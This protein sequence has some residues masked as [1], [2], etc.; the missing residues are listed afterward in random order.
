VPYGSVRHRVHDGRCPAT[1]VNGDNDH[2]G[3]ESMIRS[4]IRATSP[5]TVPVIQGL[6]KGDVVFTNLEAAVAEEGE[7]VKEG[8]GFFTPPQTLDA[9]K[10]FRFQLVVPSRQPCI[11]SE[12]KG[13]SEHDSRGGQPEDRSCQNWK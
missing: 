13:H 10:N 7:T 5:A 9:L 1:A 4:D 6:L 2:L 12:R 11:R 8:R 3:G